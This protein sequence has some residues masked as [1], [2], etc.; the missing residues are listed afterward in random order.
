[1]LA[2]TNTK[3]IP[4]SKNKYKAK[5]YPHCFCRFACYKIHEPTNL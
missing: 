3:Q 4:V 5:T 2:R 1:M